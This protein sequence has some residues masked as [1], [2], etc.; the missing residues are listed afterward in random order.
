MPHFDWFLFNELSFA[1]QSYFILRK[2]LMSIKE[3]GGEK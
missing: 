2:G 1:E 3:Q